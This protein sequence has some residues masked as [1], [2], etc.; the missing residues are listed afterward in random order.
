[1]VSLKT[2]VLEKL[3][4]LLNRVEFSLR[5]SPSSVVLKVRGEV[6]LSDEVLFL[7]M[8]LITSSRCIIEVKINRIEKATDV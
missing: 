7:G 2:V 1:M 8:F 6:I 5:N 4:S 3:S